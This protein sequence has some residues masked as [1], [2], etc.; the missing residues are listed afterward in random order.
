MLQQY[1]LLRMLELEFLR[2]VLLNALLCFPEFHQINYYYSGV[3][4]IFVVGNCKF[5]Q[6]KSENFVCQYF[7]HLIFTLTVLCNFE[8]DFI[9]HF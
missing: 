3:V 1:T 8:K 2:I 9:I 6:G 7:M 4:I 5:Y